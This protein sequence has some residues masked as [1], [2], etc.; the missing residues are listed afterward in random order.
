MKP[1]L[2]RKTH[3]RRRSAFTALLGLVMLSTIAAAV[4]IWYGIPV[5]ENRFPVVRKVADSLRR[6]IQPADEKLGQLTPERKSL[7]DRIAQ[8][9]DDLATRA[10]ATRERLAASQQRAQE[11]SA[12]VIAQVQTRFDQGVETLRARLLQLE[13]GAKR[14]TSEAQVAALQEELNQVTAEMQRRVSQL[15][16]ELERVRWQVNET[17]SQNERAVADLRESAQRNRAD[18]DAIANKLAVDRVDFEVTKNQSREVVPGISLGVTSTDVIYKRVN[19]WMKVKPDQRTIWLNGQ[20]AQEP[21]IFYGNNDGLKRELVITNVTR[22]KV[23][24]YLLVPRQSS[25]A[26]QPGEFQDPD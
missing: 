6:Q 5:L 26:D 18:V 3:K 25:G 1:I 15:N 2:V 12:A 7:V 8:A 13:S 24:G 23:A 10:A 21:V 19:G 11:S 4:L 16:E 17:G 20:G 22:D 9:K 14:D